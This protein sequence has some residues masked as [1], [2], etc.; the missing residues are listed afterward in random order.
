MYEEDSPVQL[1]FVR[2]GSTASE[3]FAA[4]HTASL[5]N[6]AAIM[7]DSI[8]LQPQTVYL[9]APDQELPLSPSVEKA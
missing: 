6:L 8:L 5:P 7:R 3:R 9:A 2:G 4:D 1:I